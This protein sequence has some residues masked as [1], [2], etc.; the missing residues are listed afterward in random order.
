MVA[1][2]PSEEPLD[3]GEVSSEHL[4]HR[5]HIPLVGPAWR[6]TAMQRKER[7]KIPRG[8]PVLWSVP[9]D[10]FFLFFSWSKRN[11]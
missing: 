3:V 7:E 8:E 10:F 11:V 4:Q 2:K 9:R 1:R 6:S 5:D